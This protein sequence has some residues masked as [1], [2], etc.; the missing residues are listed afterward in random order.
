MTLSTLVTKTNNKRFKKT[1]VVYTLITVFFFIFSRIYEHFSFGETSVYM[2]WL[3][4]VP[5]I[6]GVVLLIFQKLIPNLSRLSLNLWNSAVATIA[7]GVLFRGIV[8]LS[9]RSTTLDLPYWYV[10]I[11]LAG[12]ALLSM[13]FTRSVWEIDIQDTKKD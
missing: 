2:H 8:N 13:I 5:L 1:A 11:G 12:L 3:F 7:V 9:G 10:G 4:G 6:G